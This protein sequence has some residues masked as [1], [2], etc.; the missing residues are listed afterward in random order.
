MVISMIVVVLMMVYIF[1]LLLVG[2]IVCFRE[3]WSVFGM[4]G[5]CL[6]WLG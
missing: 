2:G 5:E 3:V 6:V 4:V 1:C